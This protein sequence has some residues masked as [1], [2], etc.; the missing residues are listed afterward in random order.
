MDPIYSK[1]TSYFNVSA[2]LQKSLESKNYLLRIG[3]V[4][5]AALKS[6]GNILS[7]VIS[8]QR[9]S[10]WGRVTDIGV[11]VL[12]SVGSIALL[13]PAILF[14]LEGVSFF[15]SGSH[16]LHLAKYE[17]ALS[18]YG[19][20]TDGFVQTFLKNK[21]F[22]E[23]PYIG[24]LL[25]ECTD[26]RTPSAKMDA[27]D[28]YQLFVKKLDEVALAIENIKTPTP[29]Q[30]ACILAAEELALDRWSGVD[31]TQ[32]YEKRIDLA[33]G[34]QQMV[35]EKIKDLPGTLKESN[36]K[37]KKAHPSTKKSKIALMLQQFQGGP[38]GNKYYTGTE[39]VPNRLGEI[40]HKGKRDPIVQLRHGSPTIGVKKSGDDTIAP[41]YELFIKAAK[42]QGKSIFYTIHQRLQKSLKQDE[43]PRTRAILA[44]QS[45][46]DNF[47]AIVQPLDGDFYVMKGKYKNV[48][49]FFLLENALVF[50]FFKNKDNPSC[51]LPES[52]RNDKVYK[53]RF[54]QIIKE[55]H[56]RYFPG[57]KMLSKQEWQDFIHIFYAYQR[58]DLRTRLPDVGYAVTAC[59][60]DLDRG[61]GQQLLEHTILLM[62]EKRAEASSTQGSSTQAKLEDLQRHTLGAP[63]NV[64]MKE[65]ISKR[66]DPILGTLERVVIPHE[67]ELNKNGKAF[68]GE[69]GPDHVEYKTQ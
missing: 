20:K 29:D 7:P 16:D 59:K 23:E 63:L 17:T 5:H 11:N 30:E 61:G 40:Y 13:A 69:N 39:N 66:L 25:K 9:R 64:K 21:H 27:R 55:V 1:S 52:L 22:H 45:K 32:Y 58:I 56:D 24:K 50:E 67:E 4:A 19:A 36:Q 68:F 42:R 34:G 12:K 51:F 28:R 49:K 41:N 3:H 10:L 60:D 6:V 54:K 2:S 31:M 18:Q 14:G 15:I 33:T 37:I 48:S 47:H 44:L 62:M 57:R 65:V 35:P 43:S 8:L 26:L 53:E 46:H 38:L